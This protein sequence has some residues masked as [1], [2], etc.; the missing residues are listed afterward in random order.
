ML[1]NIKCEVDQALHMPALCMYTC[2]YDCVLQQM[3]SII[4][5]KKQVHV[6]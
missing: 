1:C 4:S 6:Q 5:G 3:V 2:S